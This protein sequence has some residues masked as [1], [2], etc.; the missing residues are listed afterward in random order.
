MIYY[1]RGREKPPPLFFV[2]VFI[3]LSWY[4]EVL[5]C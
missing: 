3:N 2:F 4:L 1:N 5:I